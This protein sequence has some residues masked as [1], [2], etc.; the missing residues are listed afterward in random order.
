MVRILLLLCLIP[1]KSKRGWGLL[2]V[3]PLHVIWLA[4][5]RYLLAM[6]CFSIPR[7][8]A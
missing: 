1:A 8:I 4:V 6:M 7:L 3:S 5:G 2:C